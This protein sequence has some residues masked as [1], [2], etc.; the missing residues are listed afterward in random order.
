MPQLSVSQSTN[1]RNPWIF[2]YSFW[3]HFWWW[4]FILLHVHF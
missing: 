2:Y 3:L 4:F 1:S